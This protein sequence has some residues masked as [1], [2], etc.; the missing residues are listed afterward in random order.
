M[1]NEK[2]TQ[3]LPSNWDGK[4]PF[5]NDSDEDFFFTWAKKSYMFPA[6]KTVDMMRMNF[7]A[8]P[9]EVQQIRKFA[10]KQWATREFFNTSKAKQMESI[11]RNSDGSPRLQSFHSARTY[12]ETDLTEGIQRCLTPLPEGEVLVADLQT[13]DTES[14]LHKDMETGESVTSPIKNTT[15][16]INNKPGMVLVN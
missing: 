15:Q 4:F 3:V 10:A 6:R 12:S 11:E 16:S 2:F 13:R 1:P 9:L 5:T 14:E 8:T 7:N